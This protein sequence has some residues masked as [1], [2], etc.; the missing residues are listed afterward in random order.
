MCPL[1]S[2]YLNTI[3]RNWVQRLAI[4]MKCDSFISQRCNTDFTPRFSLSSPQH[5]QILKFLSK[6]HGKTSISLNVF[7]PINGIIQ[8]FCLI[9]TV[10]ITEKHSLHHNTGDIQ[11]MYNLSRLVSAWRHEICVA[12]L[13]WYKFEHFWFCKVTPVLFYVFWVFIP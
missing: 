8:K 1:T 6:T 13:F 10:K 5:L 12:L 4:A 7:S 9:Y 11:G 3:N 2:N